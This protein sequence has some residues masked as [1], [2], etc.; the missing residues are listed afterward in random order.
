MVLVQ[1]SENRKT[2]KNIDDMK[3]INNSNLTNTQNNERNFRIHQRAS[4][5]IDDLLAMKQIFKKN[6]RH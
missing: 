5:T 6:E 3:D 2:G 1:L 4:K